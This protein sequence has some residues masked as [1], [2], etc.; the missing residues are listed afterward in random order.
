MVHWLFTNSAAGNP[1]NSIFTNNWAHVF[2]FD[3][4]CWQCPFWI[5]TMLAKKLSYTDL[6]LV[7]YPH[8]TQLMCMCE[9]RS[10]LALPRIDHWRRSGH[11]HSRDTHQGS[12][13]RRGCREG[14]ISTGLRLTSSLVPRLPR[15]ANRYL[16]SCE[17]DIPVIKVGP[18]FLEQKGNVLCVVQPTMCSML[19]V[20]DIQLPIAR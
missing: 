14:W 8:V 20:S 13:R 6:Y 16:F 7:Y 12:D 5:N 10:S 1:E 4:T 19:G 15:N 18:E 17:H 9:A 2:T 11:T 3:F